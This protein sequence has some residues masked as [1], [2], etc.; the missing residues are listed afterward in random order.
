MAPW[1]TG[2][3]PSVYIHISN[4]L[5]CPIYYDKVAVLGSLGSCTDVAGLLIA[6]AAVEKTLPRFCLSL[7]SRLNLIICQ[8]LCSERNSLKARV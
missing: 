6:A 8:R 1:V 4:L 5:D 3:F 2:W 7:L